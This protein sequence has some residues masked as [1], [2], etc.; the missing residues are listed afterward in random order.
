[1]THVFDETITG[2]QGQKCCGYHL[3][4]KRQFLPQSIYVTLSCHLYFGFL[5]GVAN[6]GL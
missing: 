4:W 2:K 5:H 1:M 6:G 3:H